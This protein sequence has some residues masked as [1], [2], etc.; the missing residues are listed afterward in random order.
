MSGAETLREEPSQVSGNGSMGDAESILRHTPFL[1]AR[2]SADLRLLY[3]SPGYARMIGR[4]PNEII[5]KPIIDVMG[6]EGFNTILP[7][8]QR[9]LAGEHVEYEPIFPTGMLAIDYCM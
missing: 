5:G 9:I 4:C 1:L 8:I 7:Y 3:V 2:C 6:L